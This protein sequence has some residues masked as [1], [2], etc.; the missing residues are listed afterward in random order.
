MLTAEMLSKEKVDKQTKKL[1][2]KLFILLALCITLSGAAQPLQR[3]APEEAGLDSRRLLDADRAICDAI[4]EEGIPGAVLAVVRHGRLAYLK[5]YGNRRI[6]PAE[7]PMTTSTV[8]DMASCS[9]S[10]S[11]A[12]SVMVLV[13]QGRL[14]LLDPVSRY[15]PGFKDWTSPDGQRTTIR[16]LHLLTHTSGL[17][18]YAPVTEMEQRYGVG[19]SEGLME[20]IA[21]DCPRDFEP[22]QGFQYSC[23]NYITLQHI[24]QRISGISLRDF[25]QAHIF[26]PLG[27]THT[28]YLPCHPN[29]KG[30]WEGEADSLQYKLGGWPIAPTELQENGQVLCGQVHDPLARIM[31]GGI[32]GNAGLYSSAE[33]VAVLCAMLQNEGRYGQVRILSPAA[34][35]LMRSLPRG[36]ER[37]GRTPGWDIG[38]PYASCNGDLLSPS[39]YGHT[40]YTGTSVVIDPEQ[41]LSVILLSNAVHPRDEHSMV[42]LRTLVAN[43]VGAALL[44]EVASATPRTAHY[45]RRFVEFMD[46]E[47]DIDSSTTVMLGNS[48]TEGGGDWSRRLS[49]KHVVNRGIIGDDIPGIEARLHLI[50]PQK[51]ARIVLM[52]G[53][54]DVSHQ[55]S[56]DSITSSMRHLLQRIRRESPSTQL[57]LQS[58]LP[59]NES[60]NRYRLLAGC[61]ARVDSLNQR[62]EALSREVEGVRFVPLFSY[63]CQPDGLTLRPE[64]TADGLHLNEDGYRIWARELKK[65]LKRKSTK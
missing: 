51:P 1:M 48:L 24:V 10:L 8:F 58:L 28:D 7:E 15:I 12:L 42:R 4:R 31:N 11:T 36:L 17:P 55:L 23:L 56:V 39:T 38:S 59:I 60:F 16:V 50:L 33:D 40:G 25:A 20:Y 2:H 32:S 37:W 52:A 6:L 43:A 57:Y 61:T 30:R 34:V 49:Q 62:Y 65:A 27:L 5:A 29:A 26:R 19:N 54:N 46:T 53:I 22:T 47:H 14:R 13:D 35:R 3:V 21:T 9:K 41:D 44:P 63:F 18:P 45:Y 64:L